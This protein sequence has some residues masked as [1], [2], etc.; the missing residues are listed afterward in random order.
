MQTH[1]SFL[2]LLGIWL[3]RLFATFQDRTVQEGSSFSKSFS[4]E[5]DAIELSE[6]K[7][8]GI[9]FDLAPLM[10]ELV[11]DA[12]EEAGWMIDREIGEFPVVVDGDLANEYVNSL[13]PSIKE[14]LRRAADPKGFDIGL[15]WIYA[16]KIQGLA[17]FPGMELKGVP[18]IVDVEEANRHLATFPNFVTRYISRVNESREIAYGV[19][20]IFATESHGLPA[21]PGME[22]RKS[23]ER[24]PESVA[25]DNFLSALVSADDDLQMRLVDMPKS[26][27]IASMRDLIESHEKRRLLVPSGPGRVRLVHQALLDNW[28]PAQIW[29]EE[30]RE[31][32]SSIEAFRRT[33]ARIRRNSEDESS[34]LKE[35]IHNAVRT[36]V[37]KRSVWSPAASMDAKLSDSNNRLRQSCLDILALAEKPEELVTVV[38]GETSIFHTAARY[39]LADTIDGWLESNPDLLNFETPSGNT[40]L[41]L[42]AWGANKV[43][44][45]LIKR[46]ANITQADNAE[47]HPIISAI[48]PGRIEIFDRLLP[49][50][51]SSS[52]IVGP[53][54][55]TIFHEAA[56]SKESYFVNHLV[57]SKGDVDV[58]D[59]YRQ[60]PIFFATTDSRLENIRTLLPHANLKLFDAK[61]NNVIRVAALKNHG[62]AIR[63]IL[64]S[65]YLTNATREW[66]LV[67]PNAEN[68]KHITPLAMAA[69]NAMPDALAVLLS[70]DLKPFNNASAS[71]HFVDGL[72]PIV[73]VTAF[74]ASSRGGAPLASRVSECVSLLLSSDSLRSEDAEK[75]RQYSNHFPDAKRLIEEWLVEKGEFECIPGEDLLDWLVSSRQDVG[76]SVLVHAKGILDKRNEKGESGAFLLIS[77]GHTE[78]LKEALTKGIRPEKDP[79][80][81]E[82]EASL[83][84]F[85]RLEEPLPKSLK[86]SHPLVQHLLD[87]E[88]PSVIESILEIIPDL[89]GFFPLTHRLVIHGEFDAFEAVLSGLESLPVD[90]YQRV[91]SD[92]ASILNYERFRSIET[93]YFNETL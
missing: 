6:I 5:A 85:Q 26:S 16:T 63:E 83:A 74:N 89:S 9:F 57:S 80:L 39:D 65:E 81:F 4:D 12:W 70:E 68:S 93:E 77:K 67:G 56:R 10:T 90:T 21:V 24:I 23:T 2:P 64:W 84:L 91:P 48:Q 86:F 44:D 38:N 75:A 8:R 66:L 29:Y 92:L 45:V 40:P 34:D 54:G 32:L 31:A 13:P 41:M 1:A 47:W 42:A 76:Q 62:A 37:I 43:V 55:I 35:M 11:A 72:H 58:L 33:A 22:M 73:Q 52:S 87:E 61:G 51:E 30:Q 14:F 46:G 36:L 79:G 28:E 71:H 18:N 25:L 82:L 49:S 78:V 17:A 20:W 27:D 53:K 15:L 19:L 60:S 59:E 7:R 69:R 3:H 88:Q 50:Y